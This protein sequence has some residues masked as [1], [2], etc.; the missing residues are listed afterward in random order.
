LVDASPHTDDGGIT[1]V[2]Q[3]KVGGL[4]L[5]QRHGVRIS[6]PLLLHMFVIDGADIPTLPPSEDGP[7]AV[8]R[9]QNVAGGEGRSCPHCA[10]L[11]LDDSTIWLDVCREAGERPRYAPMRYGDRPL[12]RLNRSC[13]YRPAQGR[14]SPAGES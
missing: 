11:D 8:G 7:S 10:D 12:D 4:E 6:V 13:S 2:A 5:R 14:T 9:T 3:D 1:S